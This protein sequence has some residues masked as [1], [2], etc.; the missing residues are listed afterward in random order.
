M[1][2]CLKCFP[3][4]FTT[5]F[6]VFATLYARA[7]SFHKKNRRSLREERRFMIIIIRKSKPA[8]VTG[9][10]S[11]VASVFQSRE[12][13]KQIDIQVGFLTCIL[14]QDPFPS[15]STDSGLTSLG[16]ATISMF[17]LDIGSHRT[18]TAARPSRIFTAFP[19]DYLKAKTLSGLQ[20]IINF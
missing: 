14:P 6:C 9:G 20:P 18:L 19:F 3:H 13:H 16:F 8:G 15:G 4:T 2:T 1:L 11:V 17:F 5:P 12:Q 7:L 10:Y